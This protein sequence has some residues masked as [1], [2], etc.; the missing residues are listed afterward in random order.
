[1]SYRYLSIKASEMLELP[2]NPKRS[3]ASARSMTSATPPDEIRKL[4][5]VRYR[6]IGSTDES[7]IPRTHGWLRRF[8]ILI[9]FIAVGKNEASVMILIATWVLKDENRQGNGRSSL[10]T[11]S[12][13]RNTVPVRP[14]PK[15]A[16]TWYRV[17]PGMTAVDMWVENSLGTQDQCIA[18]VDDVIVGNQY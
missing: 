8:V 10:P 16:R 7:V 13:D 15:A 5:E 14:S 17:V 2:A 9:S 12:S 3:P 18:I 6:M 11:R 4:C 1:M